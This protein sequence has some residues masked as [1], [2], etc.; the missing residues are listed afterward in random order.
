MKLIPLYCLLFIQACGIDKDKKVDREKFTFKTGS[1]TQLFFKNVRQSYYD[2]EENKAAKFNVF[3]FKKRVKESN[4]PILNFA[5]VVNYLKDEAY[6]LLEPSK[7]VGELPVVIQSVNDSTGVSGQII[8]ESQNPKST[9]DFAA[10]LYDAMQEGHAFS[11]I[12]NSKRIQMFNNQLSREAFR[13]TISD[14][15]RLTRVL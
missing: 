7:T 5:I 15:Y 9:L 1:D 4:L 14:Y 13:I 2:L 8:L 11:L 6:L 12:Q 3:R 10:D